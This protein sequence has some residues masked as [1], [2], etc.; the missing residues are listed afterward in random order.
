M[1]GSRLAFADACG[2][3]SQRHA[4]APLVL[5]HRNATRQHLRGTIMQPGLRSVFFFFFS[6]LEYIHIRNPVS[7][8]SKISFF[9]FNLSCLGRIRQ[10]SGCWELILSGA[11]IDL[12][13]LFSGNK[14]LK[15]DRVM[16][17]CL[18]P[19]QESVDAGEQELHAHLPLV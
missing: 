13:I 16:R 9:S 1:T 2:D 8:D 11:G 3:G 5:N 12:G 15:R 10:E 17:V 14:I 7:S 19:L 4:V 18:H 6:L